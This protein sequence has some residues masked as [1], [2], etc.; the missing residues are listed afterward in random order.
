LHEHKVTGKA[1]GFKR[2]MT[3]V[4]SAVNF[5]S[6][7]GLHRRQFKALLREI[8]SEYGNILYYCEFRWPGKG[9]FLQR[10]LSPLEETKFHLIEKRQPFSKF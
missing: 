1:L 3:D 10:L 4:V 5:S 7:R 6:P 9:R 8:K 2:I